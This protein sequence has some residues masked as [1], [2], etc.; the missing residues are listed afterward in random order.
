MK[1]KTTYFFLSFVL[2]VVS[3]TKDYPQPTTSQAF[4]FVTGSQNSNQTTISAGDNGIEQTTKKYQNAMGVYEYSSTLA[5]PDTTNGKKLFQIII[6]GSSINEMDQNEIVGNS[7][8]TGNYNYANEYN[9]INES[10][11][12]LYSNCSDANAS[13]YW[14]FND[15]PAFVNEQNPTYTN[16]PLTGFDSLNLRL[17]LSNGATIKTTQYINNIY[18]NRTIPFKIES[19]TDKFIITPLIT[20]IG[21]NTDLISFTVT[22]AW[23]NAT[24]EPNTI[25]QIEIPMIYNNKVSINVIFH[26][27]LFD[28]DY[29]QYVNFELDQAFIG[30]FEIGTIRYEGASLN[31]NNIEINYRDEA[32][33]VYSSLLANNTPPTTFFTINEVVEG[34]ISPQGRP[35]KLVKAT[36]TCNLTNVFDPTMTI[37]MENMT[38]NMAFEY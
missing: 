21:E 6:N 34:N 9:L 22:T 23:P 8:H 1:N 25:Q 11:L 4:Y 29:N 12:K 19:T 30:S 17:Y 13:F 18:D 35:T 5:N 7:I 2:L 38:A 31:F 24:F 15:L 33:N 37:F 27:N 32:G 14:S 28:M 10:S 20:Q 3:C 16:L 36:F 26:D